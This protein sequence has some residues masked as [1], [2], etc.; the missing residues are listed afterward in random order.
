MINCTNVNIKQ[1]SSGETVTELQKYLTYLGLYEGNID[2]NCGE[3]TVN[4]IKKLQKQNKNTVD[5]IFGPVT[6]KASGINGTDVSNSTLTLDI[7]TW[8]DM[9]TRYNNYVSTNKKE[10]NI[11]YIDL[12][13]KY[14]YITNAK[15]KDIKIRYDEYIK[16]NKKEPNFCYINKPTNTQK[17]TTSTTQYNSSPH[18]TAKGCNKLGQCTPYYCGVH[19]LRQVLCKF[20]IED[21]TEKTLAGYAG[22]TT[23][24][25]SHQ[26]INTAVAK[27]NKNK[28][29]NIS[30][31][32]KNFSDFGN[33]TTERFKKLGELIQNSN[34][35]VI[36]HNKYRATN[37][38][39]G[40]GH[41]EVVKS[42]NIKNNTVEVLNS[43][44]N[45][46]G[47]PAYC[48]YIETRSFNTFATY[49]RYTPGGQPSIGILT[50]N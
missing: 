37:S 32:W 17:T 35:D 42:I 11:C 18:F 48:G 40:Y 14:Q 45:R 43:L 19:S 12:N 10:P 38:S 44:G 24:G 28:G 50:K 46:C 33:T 49:I 31:T 26:G 21:Y 2:G 8:K 22:T 6:C 13:N 5:G 4:A 7:G 39:N 9:M 1:G 30:I 41:Y 20:G 27:V 36:I 25:T 34:K 29:T 3:L 15:Y 23:N 47:S 16:T